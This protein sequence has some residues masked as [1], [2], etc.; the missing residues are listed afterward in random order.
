VAVLS[1]ATVATAQTSHPGPPSTRHQVQQMRTA[2]ARFHNIA[3]A[4]SAGYVQLKDLNG[5]SCIEMPP[6]AG[7]KAAAMGVHYVNPTLIANPAIDPTA[8]EA[9]VYAPERDGTLHLAALEFIVDK[10]T[11]DGAHPSR[12]PKLFAGKKFDVTPS[13]NRYGLATF[14]SQHVWVWKSNPAG[15]LAMY[16]PDVHCAWA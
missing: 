6:M 16:N 8:P 2:T 4:E 12:G 9:L 5:I 7:M 14:Y 13:P 10:A 3:T 15:L 11:W 1:T